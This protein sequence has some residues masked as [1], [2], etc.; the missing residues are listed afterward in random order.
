MLSEGLA[1]LVISH[2]PEAEARALQ[3]HP[4][5]VRGEL[6]RNRFLIVGPA[7]DPADVGAA[8]DAVDAFRRIATS[9]ASFVSRGDQSGT[10]E[11]ENL[12]WDAA[13]VRPQTER[14]IVSGRGM[15]LALRHAD[16]VRG[17]T[18]SDEA[19]FLQLQ[20]QID[21]SALYRDD[22]RLLNVYSVIYPRGEAGAGQLAAWLL[23]G[24][25]RERIRRFTIAGKQVF[26]LPP[27]V[28]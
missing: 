12:L 3:H 11:R 13:N 8:T 2:A 25:G 21:L 23:N 18:L 24:D 10:H 16:E 20:P 5:W 28:H 1:Q 9:E 6:A 7:D 14:L 26:E 4:D 22:A 27:A 17:Y 15:A 19:T